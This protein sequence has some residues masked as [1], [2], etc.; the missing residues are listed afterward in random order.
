[1]AESIFGPPVWVVEVPAKEVQAG[2][3]PIHYLPGDHTKY[4]P[5]ELDPPR[6]PDVYNM[7]FSR[8]INPRRFL[9]SR[10]LDVLRGLFPASVGA[11]VLIAG[12]IIILFDRKSDLVDAYTNVWPLELAGLRVYLDVARYETTTAPSRARTQTCTG[13]LDLKL[14]LPDGSSAITTVTHG[15]VKSPKATKESQII[16]RFQGIYAQGKASL[17][18][19]FSTCVDDQDAPAEQLTDSPIEKEVWLESSDRK[20]CL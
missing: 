7:H 3:R 18:L 20:V 17:K 16:T 14:R 1:M 12:F 15:F 4:Y 9:T 19:F 10:D 13:N 2:G 8:N 5:F 6:L 11:E